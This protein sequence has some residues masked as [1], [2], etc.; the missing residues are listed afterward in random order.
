M[1][2]LIHFLPYSAD[3]RAENETL[4]CCTD[5][6]PRFRCD[7][8]IDLIAKRPGTYHLFSSLPRVTVYRIIGERD[9]IPVSEV[10]V[11]D[12][13]RLLV[14]T[15]A[16]QTQAHAAT[17]DALN[18]IARKPGETIAVAASRLNDSLPTLI[19]D[20]ECP[21]ACEI[22]ISKRYIPKDKLQ[23]LMR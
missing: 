20:C 13:L 12:W 7:S 16:T 6:F 22:V 10:A 9:D 17:R 21:C 5:H 19:V 2:I 1:T 11:S 23:N 3:V 18:E 14:R 8:L 4:L 15:E